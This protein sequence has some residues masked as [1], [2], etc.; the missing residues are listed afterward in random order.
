[1]KNNRGAS[2][3]ELLVSFAIISMVA[4]TMFR[5]VLVLSDKLATFKISSDQNLLVGSVTN[6]IYQDLMGRKFSSLSTC[7]TNC[8]NFNYVDG[9]VEKLSLN[10]TSKLITYSSNAF[11]LPN[12][13]DFNGDMT[14]TDQVD[15]TVPENF[16]NHVLKVNIPLKNIDTNKTFHIS[17]V[18]Q[19]NYVAAVA[20]TM[21]TDGLVVWLDA[22]DTNSYPGS[23]TT[24]FD[25]SGQG[26]HFYW[27][28]P[29]PTFTTYNSVKVFS[30]T[31]TYTSVRPVKSNTFN[32]MLGGGNDY[33]LLSFF[34]P[35]QVT[36]SKMLVS[37]GS[38]T[39]L[40]SANGA[41]VHGI[42]IGTGSKFVGGSCGGLGTWAR[43]DGVTPTITRFYDVAITYSGLVENVYVDGVIDKASTMTVNVPVNS[44]NAF[45]LGWINSDAATYSMDASIGLILIYNRALSAAEIQ[46]VHNYYKARFGL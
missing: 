10:T 9:S 37:F 19:Y 22:S 30:T 12:K 27:T 41:A 43:T 6:T 14:Y 21:I 18:Y 39:S 42:A 38:I 3:V 5:T 32:G 11:K 7:G 28:S 36:A 20:P 34:R 1:M 45:T 26:N 2:I 29:A 33:T 8:Y 31:P 23:G 46:Q 4:I 15:A 44:G 24:W 25:L 16:L 35:N 40:C 17:I 13:I